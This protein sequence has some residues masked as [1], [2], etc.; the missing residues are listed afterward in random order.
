MPTYCYRC[1]TCDQTFDIQHKMAEAAPLSGPGCTKSACKL[2]KQL[3][4]VAAMV[5][6][7]SPFVAKSGQAAPIGPSERPVGH[8]EEKTHT[9]GSGCVMHKH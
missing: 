2:E 4:P 6:S 1:S 9:C 3:V 8:Q 7:P 5:K